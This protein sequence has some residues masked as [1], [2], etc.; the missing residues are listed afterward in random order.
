MRSRSHST[1]PSAPS[2]DNAFTPAYLARL[3][4]REEALTA[5]EA[6]MAGPWKVVPV[7]GKPGAV[8]VLRQWEDSDAGDRPVAEW[9]HEEP[10]LGPQTADAEGFTG[11]HGRHR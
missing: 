5:A 1:S 3:R 10:K 11:S 4:E 2:L 8:A 6:E 9:W 7:R